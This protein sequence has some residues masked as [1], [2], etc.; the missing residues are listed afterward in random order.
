MVCVLGVCLG[1]AWCVWVV[2][3]V[4]VLVCV[5]VNPVSIAEPSDHILQ[6]SV[7]KL[8][9]RSALNA[10]FFFKFL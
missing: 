3:Y 8:C 4:H 6:N 10:V 7:C 1:S 2:V 5:C 9:Y